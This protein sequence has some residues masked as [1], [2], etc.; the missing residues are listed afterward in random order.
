MTPVD[1]EEPS[2]KLLSDKKTLTAIA[3]QEDDDVEFVQESQTTVEVNAV[4]LT[5][6]HQS[7]GE[8]GCV[9]EDSGDYMQNM[10]ANSSPTA[11]ELDCRVCQRTFLSKSSLTHHMK[12]HTSNVCLVCKKSFAH[13]NMLN[14]HTCTPEV[15]SSTSRR[16]CHL[17][18]KTFANP[19][20]L[21][22]HSVVHTGER[23]Y[24]CNH[25]GKSFTQKGNLK[26]HLRRHTGERSFQC[27]DCGRV[28]AEKVS[29]TRHLM[30]HIRQEASTG[31]LR[32]ETCLQ[33][34]VV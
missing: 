4:S 23:P 27:G 12:I 5:S 17:C 28:Y 3:T 13:K 2:E 14:S 6:Q 31:E 25:C 9:G 11:T 20:A 26:C 33:M 24:T 16:S 34:S 10:E 8:N 19:S 1:A 22:I 32:E 21:K 29:L 15:S 18:G 30:T 7:G